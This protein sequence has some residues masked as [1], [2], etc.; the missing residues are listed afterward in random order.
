M[1]EQA[2]KT[3]SKRARVF[4]EL[5]EG[6]EPGKPETEVPAQTPAPVTVM[7]TPDPLAILASQGRVQVVE[8]PPGQAPKVFDTM[9]PGW[10]P[11]FD[12]AIEK[13]RAQ[14]LGAA[15][16][17]VRDIQEDCRKQVEAIKTQVEAER[18]REEKNVDAA[19]KVLDRASITFT[20]HNSDMRAQ[21]DTL[22]WLGF[23]ALSAV[24]VCVL[25]VVRYASDA[26]CVKPF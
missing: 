13:H 5:A 20:L 25:V 12:A 10:K 16:Q 21:S 23:V 3:G 2:K 14:I 15:Q 26:N 4:E 9:A 8:Q 17:Q 22:K 18:A 6:K 24:V 11:H 19:L 1:A 7:Q